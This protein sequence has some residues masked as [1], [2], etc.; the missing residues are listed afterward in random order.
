MTC[1][2][3]GISTPLHANRKCPGDGNT[4]QIILHYL[5]EQDWLRQMLAVADGYD[6]FASRA[7]QRTRSNQPEA[8]LALPACDK[9]FESLGEAVALGKPLPR[10]ADIRDTSEGGTIRSGVRSAVG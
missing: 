4:T 1:R 9:I 10:K 8:Y 7:E 2:T 5:R 3:S 6:R